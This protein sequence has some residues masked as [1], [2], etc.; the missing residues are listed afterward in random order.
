LKRVDLIRHLRNHGC[1]LSRDRGKHTIYVNKAARTM[2][3]IP[4]H[5]EIKIPVAKKICRDLKI[6]LPDPFTS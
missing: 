6:P 2:A 5:N 4:R 3:A 1:E